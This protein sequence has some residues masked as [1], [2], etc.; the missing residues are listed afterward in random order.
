MSALK[1]VPLARDGRE[2]PVTAI[3]LND[4]LIENLK[5]NIQEVQA[6]GGKF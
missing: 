5:S 2:M 1:Y 6:C 4:A 3:A